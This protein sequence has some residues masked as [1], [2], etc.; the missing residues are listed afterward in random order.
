M[1]HQIATLVCFTAVLSEQQHIP[2]QKAHKSDGGLQVNVAYS[3]KEA[4]SGSINHKVNL[5][6]VCLVDFNFD[7]G[8]VEG[9]RQC[10]H[11]IFSRLCG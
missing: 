1:S 11:K 10:S 3:L 2:R 9:R 6:K 5:K 8:S 7:V 4:K